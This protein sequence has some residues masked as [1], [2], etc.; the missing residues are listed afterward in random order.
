M[1]GVIVDGIRC[2]DKGLRVAD[3][4]G[5]TPLDFTAA[6]SSMMSLMTEGAERMQGLPA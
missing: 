4:T 5:S 3:E 1:G 6:S 2:G